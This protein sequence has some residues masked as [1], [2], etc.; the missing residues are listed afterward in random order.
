MECRNQ[1]NKLVSVWSDR[2]IQLALD[3]NSILW[4][5]SV[6]LHGDRLPPSGGMDMA[7]NTHTRLPA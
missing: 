4:N 2:G 7:V 1:G 3:R 6:Y 5:V